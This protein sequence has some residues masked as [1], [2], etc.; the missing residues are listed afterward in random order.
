LKIL[1]LLL[2]L[3]LPSTSS[4]Q[5][6][7]TPDLLIITYKL[8]RIVRID[9][10]RSGP[11]AQ[12]AGPSGLATEINPPS[13]ESRVK[14]EMKLRNNGAKTIKSVECEFLLT[15]GAGPTA[16]IGQ[17]TMNVK[18]TIGPGA[19]VKVSQWIRR[20][21]LKSWSRLQK[22]GLLHVRSSVIRIE[23]ADRSVWER[24]PLRLP[25]RD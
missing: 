11:F 2:L 7:S 1:C 16:V 14:G 25:L 4:A 10:S 21:N 3:G 17:L 15:D 8:G 19:T 5:K 6:A 12:L 24:G 20:S 18:K 22:E 13:Y 9:T 23:Y